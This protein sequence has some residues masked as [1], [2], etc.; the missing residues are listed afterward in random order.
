MFT[1]KFK[2]IM[3]IKMNKNYNS[4]EGKNPKEM[5]EMFER[6]SKTFINNMLHTIIDRSFNL[7]E[8]HEDELDAAFYEV[9]P[10]EVLTQLLNYMAGIFDLDDV[11]DHIE[12]MKE[13]LLEQKL[14][15]KVQ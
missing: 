14:M 1:V 8:A 7:V 9:L 5:K 4:L 11:F 15:K 2:N 6:D 10:F 13:L 12:T 3:E